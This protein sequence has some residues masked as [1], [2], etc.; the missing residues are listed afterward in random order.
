[1]AEKT[2]Q[3][4]DTWQEVSVRIYLQKGMNIIDLDASDEK[5]AVDTLAVSK[6]DDGTNTTVIEAESCELSGDAAV[7]ENPFASEGRYV[8]Q[9]QGKQ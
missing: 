4:S 9:M 6:N 5:L 8:S 1:M 2:V 7:A 3:G